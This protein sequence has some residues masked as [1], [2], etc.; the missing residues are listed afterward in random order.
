MVITIVIRNLDE[1]L[2]SHLKLEGLVENWIFVVSN[3]VCCTCPTTAQIWTVGFYP[4]LEKTRILSYGLSFWG[5][6]R[7]GEDEQSNMMG[8]P[9][10]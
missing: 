2:T 9:Q 1:L 6:F 10:L 5:D 3:E 4:R 8:S 7:F